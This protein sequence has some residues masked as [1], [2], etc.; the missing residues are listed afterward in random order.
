[1]QSTVVG[2]ENTLV[3]VM[4]FDRFNMIGYWLDDKRPLLWY[5][6]SY[7]QH[8]CLSRWLNDNDGF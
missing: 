6:I 3:T 2:L 7:K 4:D 1:M 8:T 5:P